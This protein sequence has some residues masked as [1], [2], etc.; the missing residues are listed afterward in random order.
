[1][2]QNAARPIKSDARIAKR[3]QITPCATYPENKGIC[4]DLI[5]HRTS[6]RIEHARC[7]SRR[8]ALQKALELTCRRVNRGLRPALKHWRAPLNIS[9]VLRTA[10]DRLTSP[11]LSF[12]SRGERFALLLSV[13]AKGFGCRPLEGRRR[14]LGGRRPKASKET[15]LKGA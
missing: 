11:L 3:N 4:A 10:R 8:R 9:A 1:L 14:V 5:S 7:R 13:V 15:A 12:I 2:A 6:R